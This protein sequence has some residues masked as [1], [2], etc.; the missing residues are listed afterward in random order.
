MD[1]RMSEIADDEQNDWWTKKSWTNN[2]REIAVLHPAERH[3]S[4]ICIP[5]HMDI[6]DYLVEIHNERLEKQG[7]Q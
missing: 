2:G 6:A 4:V 3:M 5:T 7:S 1:E